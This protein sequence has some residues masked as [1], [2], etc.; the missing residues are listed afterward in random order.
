MTP[1]S[2]RAHD[3]KH[4][5][6]PKGLIA[7]VVVYA[8]LSITDVVLRVLEGG[9]LPVAVFVL[10]LSLLIAFLFRRLW[11][12]DPRER[13]YAL[14]F[15]LFIGTLDFYF[16]FENDVASWTGQ[17]FFNL[18]EGCYLFSTAV[19]LHSLKKHPFFAESNAP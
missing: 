19:Y 4:S 3:L 11:L 10:L 5:L 9:G 15:T 16:V 2:T 6:R 12:G 1:Q 17:D 13:I 7:V 8:I 14:L 18:L